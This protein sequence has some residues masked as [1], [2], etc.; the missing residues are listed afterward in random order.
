MMDGVWVVHVARTGLTAKSRLA[1]VLPPEER[2]VLARQM[3]AR[4][5]AVSRATGP[6]GLIAVVDSAEGQA[7]ARE[8]GA[9]VLDDPGAGMNAAVEAGLAAAESA[10]A[11]GAL[12]LPG[13]LPLAE[14]DDL[15]SI[16]D[17]ARGLPC[18]V[19]VA[20]D[21]A[22]TGTNALFLRPPHVIAPDFGGASAPRH[23]AAAQRHAAAAATVSRPRLAFDL[24]TPAALARLQERIG[25]AIAAGVAGQR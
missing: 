9:L 2:A 6:E 16:V 17:A 25:H 1:P 20:T 22:G 3:L 11:T 21:E 10:G 12:V 7:L 15:E 4:L 23:L 19:V 18:A 14:P 8:M 5:L 13:D 24:D